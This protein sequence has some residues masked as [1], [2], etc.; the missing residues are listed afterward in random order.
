MDYAEIAR[1]TSPETAQKIKSD[2][3]DSLFTA[4]HG[5]TVKGEQLDALTRGAVILGIEPIDSP[6]DG[7]FIYL[8]R[9]AGDVMALLIE[10]DVDEQNGG[11][12]EVLRIRK[13]KIA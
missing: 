1:R 8:K 11:S 7:L 4:E 6:A 13:G 2:I 3:V 12:Y 5:Q 9:L 10:T